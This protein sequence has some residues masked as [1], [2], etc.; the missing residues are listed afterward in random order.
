MGSIPAL[1]LLFFFKETLAAY[2]LDILSHIHYGGH[3]TDMGW[4]GEPSVFF[5]LLHW[6]VVITIFVVDLILSFAG[7]VLGW[8]S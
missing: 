5:F 7:L 6:R 1:S 8:A 4:I 3:S 2:I